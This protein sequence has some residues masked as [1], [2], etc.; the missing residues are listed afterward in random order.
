MSTIEEQYKEQLNEPALDPFAKELVEE[1]LRYD[2][3]AM[4]TAR[5][6]RKAGLLVGMVGMLVGA[7]GVSAAAYLA[8]TKKEVQPYLISVDPR[9]GEYRQLYQVEESTLTYGDAVDIGFL[10]TYARAREEYSEPTIEHNYNVVELFSGLDE[11]KKYQT[12]INPENPNSPLT[13]YRGGVVD[14]EIRNVSFIGKGA[15]Q[16]RF[17]KRI[18]SSRASVA[19]TYHIATISYEYVRRKMTVAALGI[20]PLGMVIQDYR[21]DEET[22][23]APVTRTATGGQQ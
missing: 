5:K 12:E 21:T 9:N 6:Q 8:V 15:A 13:K 16:V 18:R 2:A 17:T 11:F 4:E 7:I 14:I 20:N 1:A 10:S 22:I 19:P 23:A 3:D